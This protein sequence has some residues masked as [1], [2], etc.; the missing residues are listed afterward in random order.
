MSPDLVPGG[1]PGMGS[2]NLGGP[3]YSDFCVLVPRWPSGH[4]FERTGEGEALTCSMRA[5][6]A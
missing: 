6:A 5:G 4:I 2:D 1:G 3:S